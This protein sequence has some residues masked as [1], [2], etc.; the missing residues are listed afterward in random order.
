VAGVIEPNDDAEEFVHDSFAPS[1]L[2]GLSRPPYVCSFRGGLAGAS[3]SAALWCDEAMV[4]REH[5]R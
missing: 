2:G 3:R 4:E 1:I 5:D